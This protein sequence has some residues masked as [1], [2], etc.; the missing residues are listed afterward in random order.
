MD[1]HRQPW[2]LWWI[3]LPLL[4]RA[5]V[6]GVL[7]GGEDHFKGEWHAETALRG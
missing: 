1:V 5:A 3:S 2:L 6:E 4:H 7:Q